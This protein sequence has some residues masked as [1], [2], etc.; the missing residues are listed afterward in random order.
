MNCSLSPYPRN[1]SI[2][3]SKQSK[4]ILQTTK[5]KNKESKKDSTKQK[6][7]TQRRTSKNRSSRMDA[8]YQ[9]E[10]YEAPYELM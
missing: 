3:H 5:I 2:R 6:D 8:K 9:Q 1:R 4:S 7:V 10:P